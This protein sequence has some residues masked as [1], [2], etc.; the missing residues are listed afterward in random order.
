MISEPQCR[1]LHN[2]IDL[3]LYRIRGLISTV[4]FG[5][6]RWCSAVGTI[7]DDIFIAR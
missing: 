1:K 5:L 3:E 2:R 6:Y 7:N 4:I